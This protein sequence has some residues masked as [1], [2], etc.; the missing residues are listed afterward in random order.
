MA[1]TQS[2]V[3][4]LI[5]GG[6]ISGCWFADKLKPQDY[7]DLTV[8]LVEATHRIGGRLESKSDTYETEVKD[9][10]G[11][12]RMFPNSMPKIKDLVTRFDLNLEPIALKDDDNLFHYDGKTVKREN[13]AELAPKGGNWAGQPP[14]AM[15]NKAK[16]AYKSTKYWADCGN[17]AYECP[18]LRNLSLHEFFKKYA[19][20]NDEDVKFW[21]AYSGYD[22]YHS[23]VQCS[24][25]VD[26]G[27]LYGSENEFQYFVKEGYNAVVAGL[28]DQ[29]R[30][31]LKPGRDFSINTKVV[32]LK[33]QG[34]KLIAITNCGESITAS[35]VILAL[36]AQQLD[37][38]TGWD[39]LISAERKAAVNGSKY[40]PLFKCFLQFDK[41]W[42]KE[43]GFLSG[44]STADNDTRQIHYYD[45]DDLLVYV[46]DGETTET[47]YATHWG[48]L[49]ASANTDKE[50]LDVL[51]SMWHEVKE[52]HKQAGVPEEAMP[53]PVW[54]KCTKKYWPAGSH[55]W[56][57]G[58][59]VPNAI[60]KIADGT[61]DESHIY[62]T[63]DAFSDKQGWVE[64]AINTCDI[65][66]GKAFG[67]NRP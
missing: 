31:G 38:I 19:N 52:V 54:E 41:P 48:D 10:L 28:F 33:R 17:L 59:D 21:F 57:K 1:Q 15:A 67:S 46:S 35:K 49:F 53:D 40:I 23:D 18:E 6:G 26:D 51:T 34:D 36:T 4:V 47:A 32:S 5:V 3:D 45:D 65:A 11:G 7:P 29:S 24:I 58:V 60:D 44:K 50:K 37:G 61:Y 25:W 63:G 42:W 43:F 13:A 8:R 9:E 39:S 12:M 27:E 62:I 55:K 56:K 2:C 30:V 22:L 20:A 14:S 66:F 64:G 16:N